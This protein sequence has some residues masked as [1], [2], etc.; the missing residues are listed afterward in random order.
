MHENY[1]KNSWLK[2]QSEALAS[3]GELKISKQ[4]ES[5]KNT[6][7]NRIDFILDEGTFEE[8]D[9]LTKSHFLE[10]NFYTDGVITGFGKIDGREV[11]IFSQDFT[12]KGGSLGIQHANKICKIMDLAAKTGCPIIGILDSGGARIDEGIHALAGYGNIFLR[13]SRYSGIIPQIS[14]VLGPCAGGA[15]YSPALTDFILTTNKISQMFI[16]GPQ[17]IKETM[18]E[19]V[20][21]EELGGAKTHATKSGISHITSET[22]EECF[23]NLKTLLSYLPSNYLTPT[24]IQPSIPKSTIDVESIIPKNSRHAYNIKDIIEAIVD[25]DSFFE[26]QAEFANNI[27]TGFANIEGEV[28]GIVANQPMMRAGAIDI[29]ASCKAAR[30]INTCNNFNITILSLVDVPGFLPGVNQEHNGIIRHGAKLIYAYSNAT[31]PKITVILRKAFGGSYIVMGSRHLGA[32]MVY[33]W[34]NAQIAVMGASGAVNILHK[35]ASGE[36][37]ET[38]KEKYSDEFLTPFIA[39]KYGYIDSIIE[40]NKTRSHIV[41]AMQITKNKVE[42]LQN[43]KFGNIPL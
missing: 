42:K 5:G 34:P 9:Q 11:A 33:A 38:L 26:I 40:P 7:R 13:N 22:E 14:V 23:Y 43:R 3:G 18:H 10:K 12:L 27:V 8:T 35:N 2:K 32:D 19:T 36:Q 24:P 29:N 4:L 6:A 30:F 16:T 37:A 15:V 31:V 39:A 28:V 25:E 41:R 20:T 17:V 21:K 1:L